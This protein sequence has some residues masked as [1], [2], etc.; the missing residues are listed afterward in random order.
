MKGISAIFCSNEGAVTGFLAATS[1]G[2]DLADG[3]K[4][5]DITVVGFDAGSAQK[6][7]VRNGWFLGSVTQD[8]YTIGYDAVE[9]CV[10]AI[11]GEKVSDIDTGAKWYDAAN[12]D[13]EYISRLVYD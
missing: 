10:K 4:Y 5:Q 7:A 9:M 3:G 11:S 1:D 8:P 6:N 12:I 2:E 13:S